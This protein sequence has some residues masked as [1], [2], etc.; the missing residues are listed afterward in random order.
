MMH[1][2]D[3]KRKKVYR[4]VSE[5]C[6]GEIILYAFL[7]WCIPPYFAA[8]CFVARS[9]FEKLQLLCNGAICLWSQVNCSQMHVLMIL[10]LRAEEFVTDI[11]LLCCSGNT[12]VLP[13]FAGLSGQATNA[14]FGYALPPN[15][16]TKAINLNYFMCPRF[17]CV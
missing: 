11:S 15:L 16:Y 6:E 13:R 10:I 17:K 7:L 8:L 4:G 12:I 2:L 3:R 1:Q 9:S 5:D 14:I